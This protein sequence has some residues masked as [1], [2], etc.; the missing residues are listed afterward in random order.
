MDPNKL[1]KKEGPVRMLKSPLEG[2]QS[3]HG[4]KRERRI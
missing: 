2:E 3:N 1:K 4:R